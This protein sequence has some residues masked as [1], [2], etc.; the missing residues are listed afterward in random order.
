MD[1]TALLVEMQHR[2]ARAEGSLAR[3]LNHLPGTAYRCQ[4]TG[5]FS[6]L[7]EFV[8]KGSL[9]LMGRP[10][11]H[12]I[13]TSNNAIERMMPR[14]DRVAARKIM[15]QCIMSRTAYKIYY[16]IC[17]PDSGEEKWI[18]DQGEG[19]YDDDGVCTHI[20]GIMMDVTAHKHRE[21]SL[22]K[23]NL[24]LRSSIK[25][26]YGLG[27]I[28]GKS[29]CMQHCYRLLLRATKGDTNVVLYGE[30]GVGKDL[31][32]RTIH[33]LSG[34]KGSYV[35]V[36]CAAIPEQLMESE[37]FGHVRG[38]FSGAV[39]AN[40]G[41][42][43]AA[44]GGTLFLDEIGELPLRLQGKLLRAL[45]SRTYTPVGSNEVRH[46]NFRLVCATNR[47]L[48]ELVKS[49]TMRSDFYYRIHVLPI[50]LPPLRERKG[51]LPLLVDVYAKKRG[52][53]EEL[54]S[55]M[56]LAMEQ[57]NWPGNVRELQNALDRYWAF[58][59]MGLEPG[60]LSEHIICFPVS[61]SPTESAQPLSKIPLGKAREE[62][63]KQ[64][65]RSVLD[66]CDWRKGKAAEALGV[67]MRTLQRKLKRYSIR[68]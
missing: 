49:G 5:D 52:E 26:S 22:R 3:L 58:G 43:A 20:E 51:D 31:A 13:G 66:Q 35:P 10:S 36:N 29:E 54:P 37:F 25:N 16:R 64:R 14:E 8:S 19:V 50:T 59:E 62:L 23:E 47:N 60:T 40:P 24:Q 39:S 18:W 67:T 42:L 68:P 1:E 21:I 55:A 38:A 4:V 61:D 53:R 63:E 34:I 11:S 6:Y 32:A 30:T 57:Y 56:L 45:E 17:L 15:Q 41:Y 27:E 48:G 2:L 44:N 7:L 33:E 9:E 65:I 46:S 28:I 12:F